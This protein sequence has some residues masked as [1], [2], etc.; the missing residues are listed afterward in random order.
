MAIKVKQSTIDDIKKKGMTKA[1]ASAKTNRSPEYQEALRRMY[2]ERRVKEAMK[3][4][5]GGSMPRATYMYKGTSP[6]AATTKRKKMTMGT[7]PG[8]PAGTGARQVSSRQK[9]GS[10]GGRAGAIAGAVGAAGAAGIYAKGKME[11]KKIAGMTK[12]EKAAYEKKRVEKVARR[13]APIAK[14]AKSKAGKTVGKVSRAVAGA[15]KT[16]AGKIVGKAVGGRVGA[17]LTVGAAA[18]G[19]GK[20]VGKAVK[21]ATTKAKSKGK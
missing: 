21:K 13:G 17:V 6:G 11:Q 5:Q 12:R 2:G 14:F 15:A 16:P 7:T 18:A 4:A 20:A 9:A 10:K 8:S 1:L 19:A 3:G